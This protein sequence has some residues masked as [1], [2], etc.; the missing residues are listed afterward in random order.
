VPA[1]FAFHASGSSAETDAPRRDVVVAAAARAGALTV[2][3][4][5]STG[6]GGKTGW[7]CSGCSD[8]E[9]ADDVG[10]V[11]AIA[12]ELSI[13]LTRSSAIG[14]DSGGSFVHRAVAEVPLAAGAVFGGALG[15]APDGT[16]SSLAR[17]IARGPATLILEHGEDD[18]VIPY[19]GGK[20]AN[21]RAF[22]PFVDAVSFWHQANGCDTSAPTT[23]MTPRT[24]T[25]TYDCAGRQVIAVR[26]VSTGHAIPDV[27]PDNAVVGFAAVVDRLLAR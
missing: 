13:D 4:Q 27:D 2:L 9:A 11:R 1:I 18:D 10:L 19:A 22:T 21:G 15:T 17:P 16:K 5:G 3:I 23:Q 8:F 7:G 24:A 20:A 26:W 12:L 6:S 14:A 25:E